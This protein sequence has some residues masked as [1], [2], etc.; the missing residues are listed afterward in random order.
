VSNHP[1]L[2]P[3]QVSPLAFPGHNAPYVD[4]L[5][6][7][8]RFAILAP[9]SHNSQ[10]WIFRMRE[11]WLELHADRSRALPVI[12]PHDREL[13][14]SCAAALF[15]LRIAARHY[16]YEPEVALLPDPAHHDLLA[17]FALGKRQ[18]ATHE[19]NTLFGAITRRHTNRFPFERREIDRVLIDKMISMASEGQASLAA[20]TKRSDRHALAQLAADGDKLQFADKRFRRELAS[21]I[22]A[23]RDHSRD[24][25]PGYAHGFS[26]L[27]SIAEPF[28][29]RTFDVGKG[30]AAKDQDMAE[31][32]P[33]LAVLSTPGDTPRDWLH[34]GEVL[35]RLLLFATADGLV[36]SFLD[37]PIEVET[38]RP[39]LASLIPGRGNPQVVLRLG[40]PT[41]EVKA[42]PRRDVHEAFRNG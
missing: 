21:W 27:I 8:T 41:R 42:T 24:G 31:H 4:K 37:Q 18:S 17:R 10:P 19:E 40:Y 39:R 25:M 9:S 35:A 11:H 30:V 3:W 16:G 34:A 32:S 26:D 20:F 38:L 12:D 7:L 6:F 33:L 13:T 22:H 29:I 2:D 14:I 28:V 5:R 15:H 36:A 1:E 23:N